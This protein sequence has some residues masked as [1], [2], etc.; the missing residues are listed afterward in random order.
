MLE[1]WLAAHYSQV[2]RDGAYRILMASG[3]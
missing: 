2:A 3:L 1:D